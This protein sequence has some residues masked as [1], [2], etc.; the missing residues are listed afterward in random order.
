MCDFAGV[1][2]KRKKRNMRKPNSTNLLLGFLGLCTVLSI[3]GAVS[4]TLAWYAYASRAALVYSGTSVFDNGQLQIGVRSE[5]EI[6]QLVTDGMEEEI[7]NGS[8]YYFAPAG[9]GLSSEYLQTYLKARN[10]AAVELYPVTSGQFDASDENHNTHVLLTPPTSENPHPNTTYNTASTSSYSFFTFAFKVYS[11]NNSGQKVF[12]PNCE[13]WL[14]YVRT[15]AS[16]SSSGNVSQS[17][18]MYIHRDETIYGANNG[19]LFNPSSE[20]NGET[21]V[22]GLLNLGY[23]EYYDFN[24]DGEILYG[25]Y[26]I[27][28]NQT[29]TGISDGPYTGEDYIYDINN[30]WDWE[31]K[32][33]TE[34]NRDAYADTFTA[35]HSPFAPKYYPNLNNVDIKTAKYY[36]TNY[37]IQTKN[38]EGDLVN[39]EGRKTS[40]CITGENCIGE[41]DATIY[42]EGWDFSVV[43]REQSHQFDF[44]LRFETNKV[45]KNNN[46]SS[47]NNE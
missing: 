32:E 8:Y 13:L 12:I 40:V 3:G 37:V 17:L 35:M 16:Q 9:E 30:K 19:F 15:R 21:K 29:T 4:S 45:N 7:V 36:G 5:I 31:T 24:D 33:N 42:L 41:F 38:S 47:S 22:G 43:D 46:N 28:E 25:D 27:K 1:N 14:T 6:P 18:R 44:Q 23:D 20:E 11:T 26:S 10:Y 2:K 39:P 34:E